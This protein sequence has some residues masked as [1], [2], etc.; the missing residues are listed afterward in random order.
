MTSSKQI[1]SNAANAQKSTGPKTP[2]GKSNSSQNATSHG[3]NSPPPWDEVTHWYRAILDDAEA[4]PDFMT[5]SERSRLALRL[6]ETEAQLRRTE[7][8]E[9][10]YLKRAFERAGDGKYVTLKDLIS[11]GNLDLSN[12]DVLKYILE[13]TKDSDEVAILNVLIKESS[14]HVSLLRKKAVTFSRY[15]RQAES[16]RRKAIRNWAVYCVKEAKLSETNPVA[17]MG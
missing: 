17:T 10:N 9:R 3:L 2:T 4:V 15:R 13:N 1:K 14:E 12:I 16:R 8:A 11:S 6:A 5:M 7:K